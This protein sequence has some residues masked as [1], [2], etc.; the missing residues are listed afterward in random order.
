MTAG[1]PLVGETWRSRVLP[2]L[3][4]R[5]DALL[6]DFDGV[7]G[8]PG[9]RFVSEQSSRARELR[10]TIF[11]KHYELAPESPNDSGAGVAGGATLHLVGDLP[12]DPPPTDMW[13]VP[14]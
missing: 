9:V 2:F 14:T 5:I 13:G 1:A 7:K 3:R 6:T 8:A 11:L 10:E 4:Y 12:L